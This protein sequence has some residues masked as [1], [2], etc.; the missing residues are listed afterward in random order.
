M[1]LETAIAVGD[2]LYIIYCTSVSVDFGT[3]SVYG[4]FLYKSV[5]NIN[6]K[7]VFVEKEISV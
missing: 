1:A 7:K 3:L 4:I 5:K 6:M 2:I